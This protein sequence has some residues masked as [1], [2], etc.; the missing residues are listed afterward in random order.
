MR[1]N[2][3]VDLTSGNLKPPHIAQGI[4]QWALNAR[5]AVK[6]PMGML[7]PWVFLVLAFAQANAIQLPSLSVTMPA[8]NPSTGQAKQPN[9]LLEKICRRAAAA[10]DE[11]QRD[12]SNRKLHDLWQQLEGVKQEVSYLRKQLDGVKR[13][14]EVEKRTT[15]QSLSRR[16]AESPSPC[17]SEMTS[18]PQSEMT[19]EPQN[20]EAPAQQ[21]RL[22]AD[23]CQM[24]HIRPSRGDGGV[25][26]EDSEPRPRDVAPMQQHSRLWVAALRGPAVHVGRGIGSLKSSAAMHAGAHIARVKGSAAELAGR[27]IDSLKSSIARTC[28]LASTCQF[29]VQARCI[30]ALCDARARARGLRQALLEKVLPRLSVILSA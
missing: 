26:A 8:F 17:L 9:L 24:M 27:H 13:E 23:A 12:P 20:D 11:L 4:R 6:L 19:P 2:S 15:A 16:L 14:L 28:A 3:K 21:N 22:C 29:T 10:A 5:N 18:E 30:E 1:F 25:L 7:R